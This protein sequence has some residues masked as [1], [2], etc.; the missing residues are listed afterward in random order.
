MSCSLH[1]RL[2]PP[3]GLLWNLKVAGRKREKHPLGRV[4]VALALDSGDPGTVFTKLGELS[5][6]V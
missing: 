1:S 4:K 5:L 3:R 6:P 2:S